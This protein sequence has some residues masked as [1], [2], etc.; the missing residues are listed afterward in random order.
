MKIV[1]AQ[2]HIWSGGKPGNPRH[3]QIPAFTKDDLLK[4]MAAAGV[5]AAVIHP[6]TSWDPNANALAIE[7]A[8]T[9]PDRFAILGN[10]PLDKPESRALIDGW[11]R[12]PGMLG[13][14][15]TFLQPHMKSWPTDGTIEW[16]WS[17]AE[18]AGLPV[19][20]LA[21][22][23]LPK[24]GQVAERHPNLKLIID[25]L[26]RRSPAETG[27]G[28]WDN[29]PQMLALANYPNIAIK[30]TGA[31]S[32]S[33]EAYP[34]RDIHDKLKRI[35]DA[36]GPARMFWGTDI[37]RMPC[38]YRQ[39]VTMFTEELPWLK[40]RDAELVMGRGVCEWIGW[41]LPL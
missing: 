6:P 20:L 41:D 7:A 39:C 18:R 8:R 31:P 14:R 15:F 10:F 23:F 28:A 35:F 36:F 38:P 37:T 34:F 21:A 29:L 32:Y 3:R 12:Q 13:L 22:N 11:K 26:G 9:H 24:V 40:G 19:A 17:A 1:D 2:V 4:E 33:A 30:A 25:H 27:E 16:L 5:D